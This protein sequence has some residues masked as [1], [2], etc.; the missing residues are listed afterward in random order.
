[1]GNWLNCFQFILGFIS[2]PFALSQ[3]LDKCFGGLVV[4]N[5]LLLLSIQT[6]L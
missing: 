5:G 4:L 3:Y 1:V 2:E 6:L